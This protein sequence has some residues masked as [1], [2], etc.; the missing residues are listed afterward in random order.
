M[1]TPNDEQI[2]EVT[3]ALADGD[4]IEAIK[5][6]REATGKGLKESKDFIDALIPKLLEED[7]ETYSKLKLGGGCV[8]LVVF[9]LLFSGALV[10]MC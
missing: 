8:S 5:I 4:K 10:W 2:A 6:Y 1:D 3:K 9:V 7:P